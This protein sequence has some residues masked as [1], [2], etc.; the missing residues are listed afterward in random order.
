LSKE[1]FFCV[2]RV[3]FSLTWLMCDWKLKVQYLKSFNRFYHVSL[4]YEFKDV[5]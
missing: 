1:D 4:A 3:F 2:V 5:R